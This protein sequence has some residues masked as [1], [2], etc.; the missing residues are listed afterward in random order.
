MWM[1][2]RTGL[3]AALLGP[4]RVT[5]NWKGTPLKITEKT[6]Y[7]NDLSFDFEIDAA[8][9]VN[10]TLAIRKPAWST[11]ESINFSYTVKDGY[12]LITRNWQPGESL[13]IRLMTDVMTRKDRRN[14]AYF[15]YGP[16]VLARPF[17]AIADTIRRYALPG[18]YDYHYRPEN[19]VV[20]SYAGEPVE[21][22]GNERFEAILFDSLH[23]SKAHVWLK[24]MGGTI[25]RQVTFPSSTP[26]NKP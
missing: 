13:H 21:H 6:T 7:P 5:T 11:G 19:L 23:N 26:A 15:T 22:S 1:R 3:V 9:A 16:L 2:S 24:P 14:A 8:Q 4:C 18:F 20:Y 17:T 25:L 12:F 10:F